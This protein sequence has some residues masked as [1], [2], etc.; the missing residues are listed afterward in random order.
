ML[1]DHYIEECLRD[2]WEEISQD[3]NWN[4]N[5]RLFL[6]GDTVRKLYTGDASDNIAVITELYRR[7]DLAGV[8]ELVLPSQILTSGDEVAGFEM[9]RAEGVSLDTALK[10]MSFSEKM[11]VFANIAGFI[12]RLPADLIWGDVHGRNIIC[13]EDGIRIVD[14]DGFGL[15]C[16]QQNFADMYP[17]KYT[18]L[19]GTFRISRDSDILGL[20]DIALESILDGHSFYMLPSHWQTAFLKYL[21]K[22]GAYALAE[23][24]RSTLGSG[25]CLIS[26]GAFD[27][28]GIREDITYDR[29]LQQSG[30]WKEEQSSELLLDRMIQERDK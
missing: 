2:G 14:P 25:P 4:A 21:E 3:G 16:P 20:C 9:P 19:N 12:A 29:F 10:D 5:S 6:K 7:S 15:S 24:V 23:T 28:S 18:D 26:E 1:E 30:L 8:P 11:E 27:I 22:A 13:T 17:P